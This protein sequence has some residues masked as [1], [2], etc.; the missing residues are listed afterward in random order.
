MSDVNAGD[1]FDSRDFV[2]TLA[3]HPGVYRMLDGGGNV[4]YVGKARNLKRRVGSYFGR[5][6]DS[7]KTRRMVAET[8][9]M[10][11]TVTHTE[12]EALLLENHLIKKHRP[13][14]NVLLR[15]DKSYPYIFLS[16]DPFPRLAFHR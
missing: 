8:R 1:A 14:F 11:V 5:R 16:S 15:D 13:R 12:A 4:I 7:P 9:D 6:H 3:S 2:R 10:E